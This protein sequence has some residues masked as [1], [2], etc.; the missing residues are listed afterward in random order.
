MINFL[1]E[2]TISL[3][4][5]LAF[6]YLF[7]ER[8]KMHQFN[9][10]YLLFSI[11]IS[12]IIPFI[13]IE[14]IQEIKTS[15][16]PYIFPEII[17]SDTTIPVKESI[18]YT[19]ILL[20]SFYSIVSLIL[21]FRFLKNIYY[22]KKTI[23]NNEKV[24]FNKATLVL[25][26]QETIPHTFLNYIFF[27]KESYNNRTIENELYDHELT[28]VNQKHTY[29]ILGIE[30]L[31]IIFWFNPIFYFYKKAIQLNHEF[32]ADENVVKT[33]TNVPFYQSL[34]LNTNKNTNY[35]LASN[36]N[37]LLTKKRLIMM[38]KTTSKKISIL[39]KMIIAPVILGLVFFLCF[40]TIAQ[41]KN[42][43]D[44]KITTNTK[45][46]TIV[47]NVSEKTDVEKYYENTTFI[48]KNKEKVVIKECKFSELTDDDKKTMELHYLR[49]TKSVEKIKVTSV[50]FNNFKN[51]KKYA[52]W[53]D[54]K[55]VSNSELNKYSETDFVHFF[56]SFVHKNARSKNFPQ[57]HQVSL[58]TEEGF[59]LAFPKKAEIA[60][61][62]I[63]LL[64]NGDSI[65]GIVL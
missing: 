39:K 55:Q 18:D 34:L 33:H 4:V 65:N 43:T 60:Q 56:N 28:H 49:A 35:Y 13:S 2:S 14:V 27:N 52:I 12:L 57:E 58:Y 19:P 21:L 61:P 11:V 17:N 54:G 1:I 29:D 6:Y 30:L 40:K 23:Q 41:E 32:I 50:D 48:V 22:F 44:N 42:K 7:L 10:F 25:L 16:I 51:I 62:S 31:K 8:E 20:W 37:Y 53:I 26:N 38:T 47:N 46:S 59:K 64:K 9:R 15:N 63:T 5:L 45:E 36:L 24:S 3:V